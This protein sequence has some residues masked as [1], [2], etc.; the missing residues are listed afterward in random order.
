MKKLLTTLFA[1]SAISVVVVLRCGRRGQIRL[2]CTATY[3]KEVRKSHPDLIL[4]DIGDAIQD[5]QVEVFAKTEKYYKD[6]PV[7]KMLNA[8][9]YDIFILGNHE[10]N[11]GMT[12]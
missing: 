4:V 2:L 11:F 9:N 7:P 8:M 12:A 3:V 1:L 10:F 5:N 6:N